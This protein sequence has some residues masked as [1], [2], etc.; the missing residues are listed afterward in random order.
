MFQVGCCGVSGPED[1]GHT[2][3]GQGHQERLPHSCCHST[4]SGASHTCAATRVQRHVYR[5]TWLVAGICS[6]SE[7]EAGAGSVLYTQ[8]CHGKLVALAER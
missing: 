2:S 5:D 7:W 4:T 1:W 6:Y 8:G 3:W